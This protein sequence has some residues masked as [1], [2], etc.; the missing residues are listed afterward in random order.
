[1]IQEPRIIRVFPRSTKATPVD[2]LAFVGHPPLL[3]PEADEVHISV[4]FT[5]DLP[6]ARKLVKSWGALYPIV[7]IGGPALGDPGGEFTPGRYLKAG[8]VITS[9]GCPNRCRRC[10]VPK[11]EGGLRLLKIRPG[12][13]ILDNNLLACPR[14][15]IEEVLEMLQ[16]QKE[17]ARFSGGIEAA[18]VEP[19]FAKAIA[20]A[21]L[22]TLILAYDHPSQRNPVER[23]VKMIRDEAGWTD[24]TSRKRLGCFVL[25][26]FPGDSIGEAHERLEWITSLGVRAYPMFFRDDSGRLSI[27]PPWYEMMRPYLRPSIRYSRKDPPGGGLLGLIKRRSGR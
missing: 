24:G 21:R 18:R 15:H 4:T 27:P 8:Y 17:R 19:W 26:G 9:R 12:W 7:K 11:R 1:M 14:S 6:R 5:W 23:A 25:C 20:S 22:E 2:P 16:G 10:F 13:D 3:R